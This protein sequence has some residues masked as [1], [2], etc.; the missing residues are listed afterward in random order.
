M[1]ECTQEIGYI[2]TINSDNYLPQKSPFTG[3]FFLD[4]DILHSLYESYLSTGHTV[5]YR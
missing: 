5:L 1:T 2:Q 3:Q 4:D